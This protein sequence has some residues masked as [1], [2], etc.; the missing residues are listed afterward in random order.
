MLQNAFGCLVSIFSSLDGLN[1]G[2]KSQITFHRKYKYVGIMTW[3]QNNKE[4]N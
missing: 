3:Q 4:I 2:E 1:F